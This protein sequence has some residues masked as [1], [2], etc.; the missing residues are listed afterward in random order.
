MTEAGDAPVSS[1]A[2]RVLVLRLAWPAVAVTALTTGAL[3]H[4]YE[5]AKAQATF[6]DAHNL[7][8][9]PPD[10]APMLAGSILGAGVTLLIAGATVEVATGTRIVDPPRLTAAR[11]AAFV[12]SARARRAVAAARVAKIYPA[13][14][15]AGR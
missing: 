7:P 10:P 3:F 9:P 8:F 2:A 4:I 13:P 15:A 14:H 6:I 1:S 11:L 5:T 12:R